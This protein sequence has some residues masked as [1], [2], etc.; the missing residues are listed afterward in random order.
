MKVKRRLPRHKKAYS[1]KSEQVRKMTELETIVSSLRRDLLEKRTTKITLRTNAGKQF[2]KVL[3][4][5]QKIKVK[6]DTKT[7]TYTVTPMMCD[8]NSANRQ[9]IRARDVL[10]LAAE[11]LP[12]VTGSLILTTRLGIITHLQAAEENVGGRIIAY[13]Y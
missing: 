1:V 3:L 10:C 9:P 11:Q 12:S 4:N 6:V 5:E 13:V 8:I 7:N 2:I